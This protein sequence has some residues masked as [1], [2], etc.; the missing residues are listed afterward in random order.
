MG[1]EEVVEGI[2][3]VAEA[4]GAAILVLGALWAL[5]VFVRDVA[6][7]GRRSG[8]YAAVR[9][10]IGRVILLGLE[11]LI[12]ADIVRTIVVDP[13]IESVVV[14]GLIVVIR[15]ILSFSLEVEMDGSWPWQRWR[16]RSSD[17]GRGGD[18]TAPPSS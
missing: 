17:D 14:L 2:V 8:A 6:D 12:I 15:I 10:N 9:R 18:R 16:L 11:V 1:F 3:R 13:T 7:H 4:V 5:A